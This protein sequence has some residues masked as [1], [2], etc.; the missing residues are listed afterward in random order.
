[1]G[2]VVKR[3]REMRHRTLDDLAHEAGISRRTL[4]YVEAGA[5]A[6]TVENLRDIAHALG[7]TLSALIAEAEIDPDDASS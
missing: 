4:A 6:V 1:L 3:R 2:Q 7:V 5:H